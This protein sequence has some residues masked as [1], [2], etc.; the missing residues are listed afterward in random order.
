MPSPHKITRCY[1]S[2]SSSSIS[3][4]ATRPYLT[5]FL[6]TDDHPQ[7]NLSKWIQLPQQQ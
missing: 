6:A 4:T 2:S 7:I 5:L 3:S 1:G